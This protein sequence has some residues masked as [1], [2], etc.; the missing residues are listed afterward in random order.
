MAEIKN[1]TMNFSCS[2][3]GCLA[4]LRKLSCIECIV[5]ER[6]NQS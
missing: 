5:Y 6:F 1:H 3:P 2:R 4:S